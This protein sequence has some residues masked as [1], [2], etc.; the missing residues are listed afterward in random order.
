MRSRSVPE[1][2]VNCRQLWIPVRGTLGLVLTAKQRG[3]ITAA[4]PILENLRSLGN[5]SL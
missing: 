4:R 5:V 3:K 2:I 1:A